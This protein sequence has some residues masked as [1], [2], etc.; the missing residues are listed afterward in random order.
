MGL[1]H[2]AGHEIV[3]DCALADA[4]VINTCG[5]LAS[6][7]RESSREIAKLIV[8]KRAGKLKKIVVAGCLA[9]R[10]GGALLKKFPGI[11]SLLGLSAEGGIT[12]ALK[13]KTVRVD[14]PPAALCA[15]KARMTATL[16]HSVYLKIADGCDNRCSY[17]AIPG[18]RGPFRSKPV[19]DVVAEARALAANGAREISLI[20]QDTTLYGTD[21]YGKVS[22]VRL[23]RELVKTKGVRWL[24]LMYA[25][26]DRIDDSLLRFIADNPKICRYVDMPVQHASDH[27]LKLMNRRSTQESLAET[28][29]RLRRIRDMALRTTF[30]AGFPGEMR[31][32]FK[33]L[34]DFLLREKF[35]SAAI[36]AFSPEKGTP[37]WALSGKIP[38]AV[39]NRRADELARLQSRVVDGLNRELAGKTVTVLM[40]SPSCGRMESQAPDVDGHVEI[41]SSAPLRAGDFIKAKIVS[42]RGYAR[43]AV[44]VSKLP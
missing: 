26:P 43:K 18:I 30:M 32:D 23:L 13:T 3:S 41:Q 38:A 36:F 27:V 28:V 10:S 42:A 19:E 5:F 21:L 29:R 25:Y 17:C 9:Q 40:D 24:R 7:A 15:P 6:A 4:A 20:A 14:A 12:A 22:L 35:D 1:L 31:K 39:R 16:P 33:I 8:L 44:F 2:G 11:D 34:K 37:A